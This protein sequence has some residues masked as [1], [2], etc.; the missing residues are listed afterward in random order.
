MILI[1]SFCVIE[2]LALTYLI[3]YI[4]ILSTQYEI[5]E[6]SI[7]KE[8]IETIKATYINFEITND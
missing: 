5:N 6:Y 3:E 8:L 2:L 7:M 4:I 1:D